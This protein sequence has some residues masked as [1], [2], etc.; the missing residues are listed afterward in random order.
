MR[1]LQLI[2]SLRPGGAEKMSVTYAKALSK[3]IDSSYLCCTRLEGMLKGQLSPQ[4]GYLFLGKK[5]TLDV[6]AF[7]KL[8]QY[9]KK[10]RIDILQA[11]SSSWFL[12][13]LVKLSLPQL[14]LVWHD[15]FGRVLEQRQAGILKPG[16]K[17]F[18]GIIS[19]NKNLEQWAQENL[20]C[21]RAQYF[22]NFLPETKGDG[23]N[24]EP[25]PPVEMSGSF[26]IICVANLRPQK[27][28][29]TL[30]E[31]FHIFSEEKEE[32][33][34]HLVGKNWEDDYSEEIKKYIRDQNLEERVFLHGEQREISGF[35]AYAD[36]GVLSSS[37]EGLPVALLEYGMAGL[38]VICTRV[39]ECEWVIGEDG[40]LVSPGNPQELTLAL[41]SYFDNPILAK[42]CA[43]RFQK[44]IEREYSEEAVFPEVISF[45][46]RI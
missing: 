10:N 28:H 38:P 5:Y 11:H 23:S 9:V 15:H 30:L 40:I 46:K 43:S 19:V 12:A 45:F 36:I 21:R 37:S 41:Q 1:V 14:T 29:L 39:G 17:Y 2:D 44:K 34:L 35:L 7:W 42:G 31:A 6:Q 27:D 18:D 16:S 26:K 22:P 32:I 13:L 24:A 33:S 25:D 4:V 20:S 8:R 3:R